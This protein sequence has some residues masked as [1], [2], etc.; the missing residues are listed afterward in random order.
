MFNINEDN[1]PYPYERFRQKI[2]DDLTF[3]V[4]GL[5]A[6]LRLF[7]LSK[8]KTYAKKKVLFITSSEENAIKYQSDLNT[9]FGLKSEIIPFQDVSMYE[10]VPLNLYN[11]AKQIE[12]LEAKPDIVICPVKALLE[13]FPDHDFFKKNCFKIK[14]GDTLDLGKFSKKLVDL[15][16]KKETM[17]NDIGEFSIRGDIADIFSLNSNPV[18]IELWGDEV[19]DIRY[20][21]NVNDTL[22]SY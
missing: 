2:K 10:A 19:V 3:S 14:I 9:I 21:N 22:K 15:G 16:Y 5:T 13:K 7:L 6:F 18:R 17:V 11:Y 12:I 4:T 20:F 8:I 1:I